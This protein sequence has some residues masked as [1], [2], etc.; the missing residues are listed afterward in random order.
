MEAAPTGG[1]RVGGR[2]AP[3]VLAIK[4]A[5]EAGT[6]DLTIDPEDPRLLVLLD[7]IAQYRGNPSDGAPS[8]DAEGQN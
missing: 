7:D 8:G 2:P 5:Y 3:R 6:L 1:R 4:R